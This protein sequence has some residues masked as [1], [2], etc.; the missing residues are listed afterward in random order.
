MNTRNKQI[1]VAVLLAIMIASPIAQADTKVTSGSSFDQFYNAVMNTSGNPKSTA[2]SSNTNALIAFSMPPTAVAPKVTRRT[3]TVQMSAYNSEV[4]QTDDSPFIMANGNHVHDGAVAAN[5]IDANGR[6]IPFGTLIK[7][8]SIYGDK[9]F[10]V[11][12]RMN[13]RYTNNV[14]IWMESHADA[15]K[16]GRRTVQIEIIK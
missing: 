4:G 2:V 14:D 9:I 6:N 1:L 11:E 8:P 3:L 10:I 15:I 13:R 7:I 16:F 12:D 5:I